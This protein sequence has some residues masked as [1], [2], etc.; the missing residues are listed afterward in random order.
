M[1]FGSG[2]NPNP[3]FNWG[4]GDGTVNKR[5]LVG[6]AYWRDTPAQNNKTIY[7]QE[8]PGIEHYNLLSKASVINYILGRLDRDANYPLKS[9]HKNSTNPMKFRLF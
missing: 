1:D 7:L 2:F 9:E 5:S 3:A 8:F 4:N 6:C